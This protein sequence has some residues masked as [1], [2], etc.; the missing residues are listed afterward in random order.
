[1]EKNLYWSFFVLIAIIAGL[2]LLML[3]TSSGSSPEIK[4]ILNISNT[5]EQSDELLKLLERVGPLEAQE[6]LLRS[7]LPFTGQSH[8]LVHTVGDYIYD[9][10][11][12][13][14]LPYCKD[15]FLSA[16]YHGFIINT[17]GDYGIE[18]MVNA[19][20]RCNAAP[21]GVAA[22]CAHAAGHG[23]VAWHDY[24]LVKGAEMC[25]EL[26]A[27]VEN[28]AHFN[29]YDG[30]FMENVWGVH[31]GAPSEKRWV[32]ETDIYYPCTDPRIPGKYLGGCWAN[33]ATLIFQTY[34]GDLRKTAL[35]CDAVENGEYVNICYNNLFRQIHPMTDGDK[36][37]VF[38]LCSNAT[39]KERQDECVLTNMVSY[40]SVG[41]HKI[42]FD[43][44]NTLSNQLKE[45]CFE[46][47]SGMIK[48]SYSQDPEKREFYCGQ[49]SSNIQKNKCLR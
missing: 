37:G 43:I 6:E 20:E 22:Q 48:F 35:A 30:V 34:R 46:R 29:C 3:R 25:D 27:K 44:C 16:C 47:L 15:Y 31:D 40:W 32:S 42:P 13:E 38:S 49:I 18:G 14:G 10:Y 33:Q 5:S 41:D 26:G 21:P 12:P 2:A 39:G 23:F 28:F 9:N 45:S 4:R 8:L 11:G 36:N 7:G 1:M 19:M 17:L 24:D